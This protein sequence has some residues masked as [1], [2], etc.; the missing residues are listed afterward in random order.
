MMIPNIDP[1]HPTRWI[2]PTVLF[3]L[4]AVTAAIVYAVYHFIFKKRGPRS[5]ALARRES[6]LHPDALVHI[7]RRFLRA[8]PWRH[9]AS[10]A[11]YPTVVVLGPAGA[12]KSKLVDEQVDWQA[13][14]KRFFP[15]VT[16]DPLL[17]VYIGGRVIVQEVSAALLADDSADA[18]RALKRLWRVSAGKR[19]PGVLLV[20]DATALGNAPPEELRRQAQLLRGKIDLLGELH[21]RPMRVGICLTHMD[22]FTGFAELASVCNRQQLPLA[23]DLRTIAASRDIREVR[24]FGEHEEYL[25]LALTA[26]PAESFNRVVEL[27]SSS[28]G[29]GASLGVFLGP[30]GERSRLSA[31]PELDR[32]FF[33][34]P[35]AAVDRVLA[36]PPVDARRASPLRRHLIR[37]A[38]AASALTLLLGG[39]HCNHAHKLHEAQAAVASYEQLAAHGPAAGAAPELRAAVERADNALT[40]LRSS[41]SWWPLLKLSSRGEKRRLAARTVE[42]TR[43]VYLLPRLRR[44]SIE[45]RELTLYVIG[46]I[47]AANDNAL[48]ELIFPRAKHWATNL[49]MPETAVTSYIR[50]S[51]HAYAD[52]VPLLAT[53]DANDPT[54]S[55][56]PWADFLA[57]LQAAYDS[58][59][60]GQDLHQLQLQA[61][62]LY[63]A[64]DR[65]RTFSEVPTLLRLLPD[66][67]PVDINAFLKA[68]GRDEALGWIAQNRPSLEGL[69]SMIRESELS[70]QLL[71]RMTL[72]ALLAHVNKLLAA[73]AG[74][75]FAVQLGRN[76][77]FGRQRWS[78]IL[79]RASVQLY[80]RQPGYPF[81]PREAPQPVNP[82]AV[83]PNAFAAAPPAPPPGTTTG[84]VYHRLVVEGTVRPAL[85]EFSQK[86]PASPLPAADKATLAA[87]ALE[88]ANAYAEH[89][90]EALF[91][92]YQPYHLDVHTAQE[93]AGALTQLIQPSGG[94]MR[95]LRAVADD[96]DLGNLDSLYLR[97]LAD[98]VAPLQPIVR[99]IK[100]GKDAGPGELGKYIALVTKLS[101]ELAGTE[102]TGGAMLAS[103]GAMPP[104]PTQGAGYG[105]E[106]AGGGDGLQRLLSPVGKVTVTMLLQ[107]DTS[108]LAQ[109]NQFL[110][111]V[112]IGDQL[113]A[114]FLEPFNRV[115]DFGVPEV[116][117]ALKQHWT[118]TWGQVAPMFGKYPFRRRASREVEPNEIDMLKE[119]GGA[120]WQSFR[121][122][123]PFCVQ[124]GDSWSA[125]PSL[126][127]P[128]ALPQGML[129]RVNL[130]ARLARAYFDRDGKR[131]PLALS[132]TPLPLPK[133]LDR[134]GYV[135]MSFL[136]AGG[137]TVFGFNQQPTARAFSPSWW[138]SD[139]ASLGIMFGDPNS[140]ETP[141]HADRSVDASASPWSLYR[142][143]EKASFVGDTAVWT[144]PGDG[145]R[146]RT[147]PVRFV[148]RGDAVALH[149]WTLFSSAGE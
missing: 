73:G 101:R 51:D 38:V 54:L 147:V 23:V 93:L 140:K 97:P 43:A 64:L 78:E 61:S 127:R 7:W 84:D 42:S 14:K 102:P 29:I 133:E 95:W 60:V 33:F 68:P 108:Y 15:S 50:W 116:E 25:A 19:A 99:L 125:R 110:S 142:L 134:S 115:L 109:A 21:G 79:T 72:A 67:A 28:G 13:Q 3:T 81:L 87:Y 71:G 40:A 37:F 119:N 139:G 26:S 98:A 36:T 46:L 136:R 82:A 107:P 45:N 122:L 126:A 49:N 85:L 100:P 120:F 106:P 55:L 80:V 92:Q 4:T 132:A 56:K 32:L 104:P 70:P 83:D 62:A 89:Y 137:S 131:A 10:I 8:Q 121:E 144:L 9:R 76:Y 88:Q 135:T 117:R 69:L 143:L 105:S 11:E 44:G 35:G 86:L 30:L 123:A 58:Q 141:D 111:E 24:I 20:I 18:R 66:H 22:A 31:A 149:P 63:D 129:G 75:T 138:G 90:R 1:M 118:R 34:A 12:G 103:A 48:G 16:D 130:I 65:S 112:G 59:D 114:P 74:E 52:A 113:K 2:L 148:L 146:R 77:S 96:A 94:F 17:Q 27:M 145:A 57:S 6:T 47:Y 41:E 91:A 128:L 53:S 39:A 124:R 5:T